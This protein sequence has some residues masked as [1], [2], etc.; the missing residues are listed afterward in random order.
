MS[1]MPALS[2]A[3]D[4]EPDHAAPVYGVR[5]SSANSASSPGA[6]SAFITSTYSSARRVEASPLTA[7]GAYH[8]P[9]SAWNIV[10]TGY[11]VSRSAALRGEPADPVGGDGGH[12]GVWMPSKADRNT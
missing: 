7:I 8:F 10:A 6:A 9:V 2:S 4:G 3:R 11:S 5:V 12:A 1:S